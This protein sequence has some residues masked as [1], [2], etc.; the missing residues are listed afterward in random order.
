MSF[1]VFSMTAMPLEFHWIYAVK[2]Q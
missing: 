1:Y 2:N